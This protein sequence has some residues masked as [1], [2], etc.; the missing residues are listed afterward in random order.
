[1]NEKPQCVVYWL[2]DDRCVCPW[3]HGYIGISIN[4]TS[5]LKRHRSKRGTIKI[6]QFEATVLFR[7]TV[8]ECFALEREIR[9]NP[10]VGWNIA[11]GGVGPQY[12]K[13]SETIRKMREAALR[14]YQD[15]QERIKMSE[16][17]KGRKVTWG[18]KI[19]AGKRGAKLSDATKEK[20]SAVRKGRPAPARTPEHCTAISIAK[21]G[22]PNAIVAESN[23]RRKGEVRGSHSKEHCEKLSLAAK[24]RSAQTLAKMSISAKRRDAIRQRNEHGQYT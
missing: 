4:L 7:G 22:K 5:R 8:D 12:P 15:P 14:R 11:E 16:I 2:R 1:M 24:N 17:Q 3:R 18:A 6:K 13:P 23:R 10:F 20:M 9:P 19:S 21:R